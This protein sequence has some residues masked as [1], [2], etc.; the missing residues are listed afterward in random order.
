MDDFFLNRVIT[1]VENA[2]GG[3]AQKEVLT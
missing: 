1:P 2:A 3:D